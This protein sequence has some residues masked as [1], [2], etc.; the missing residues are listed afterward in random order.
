MLK[1]SPHWVDR[2]GWRCMVLGLAVMAVISLAD[3]ALGFGD[4]GIPGAG[5]MAHVAGVA[6]WI[7]VL[8]A[9]A[10]AI[11]QVWACPRRSPAARRD[12]G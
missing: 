5:L 7:S 12:E 1:T 6:F 2:L 9:T 4:T 10:G 3:I 11:G 8:S